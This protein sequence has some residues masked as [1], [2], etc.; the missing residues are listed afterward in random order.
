[1]RIQIGRCCSAL[2][3]A[4]WL[5]FSFFLSARP[6]WAEPQ[7]DSHS[8]EVITGVVRDASGAPAA[9]ARVSFLPGQYMEA[10]IYSETT[11]DTQGAYRLPILH[12]QARGNDPVTWIGHVN[13]THLVLAQDSRH[14][15]SAIAEFA[16]VPRQLDMELKPGVCLQ[17]TAKDVSGAAISG[18]RFLLFVSLSEHNGMIPIRRLWAQ[19]VPVDAQGRFLVAGLPRHHMYSV[20]VTAPGFGLGGK[21]IKEHATDGN[22]YDFGDIT[23]KRADGTVGGVAVGLDGTPLEDAS[24]GLSGSGQVENNS[25]R[26]D[27]HGRFL[28]TNVCDGEVRL[29]GFWADMQKVKIDPRNMNNYLRTPARP[30]P[31]AK[32]GDTN[33]ILRLTPDL[34]KGGLL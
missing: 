21:D 33:V 16:G 15:L 20:M 32:P 23:I 12:E 34:P 28:F 18:A 17:G 1:M 6:A 9:D 5:V 31:H 30:S 22:N 24:V 14:N 25:V 29:D 4:R 26:T 8:S 11:T 13:P 27:S 10:P 19:P 2:I 3:R 7:A